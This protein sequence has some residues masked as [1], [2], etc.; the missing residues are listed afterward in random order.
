MDSERNGVLT[1]THTAKERERE[2]EIESENSINYN[3]QL[4]A[5]I[6]EDAFPFTHNHHYNT[7]ASVT[8]TP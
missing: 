4:G 1:H 2:R 8:Y 3:Y 5:K 7:Y 6:L